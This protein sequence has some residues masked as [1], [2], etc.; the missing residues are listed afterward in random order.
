MYNQLLTAY[1]NGTITRKTACRVLIK[2]GLK[3]EYIAMLLLYPLNRVNDIIELDDN[4]IDNYDG[5]EI[6]KITD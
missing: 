1:R 2:N 6:S 4:F 5:T 3:N